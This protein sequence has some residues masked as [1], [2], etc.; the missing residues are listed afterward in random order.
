MARPCEACHYLL[1]NEV[2]LSLFIVC[3]Q[4]CGFAICLMKAIGCSFPDMPAHMHFLMDSDQTVHLRTLI[5]QLMFV[6]K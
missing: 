4:I 3:S 2:H 6:S 5:A 1:L